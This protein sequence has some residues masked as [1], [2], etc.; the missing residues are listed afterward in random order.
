MQRP[1]ERSCFVRTPYSFGGF[2]N[3]DWRTALA[4]N[5]HNIQASDLEHLLMYLAITQSD[6]VKLMTT[7]IRQIVFPVLSSMF[8]ITFQKL[9]I[10]RPAL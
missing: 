1:L 9:L 3:L 6:A 5:L 8:T 7:P 4:S 2:R 10:S